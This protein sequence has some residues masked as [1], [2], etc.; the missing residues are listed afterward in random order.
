MKKLLFSLLLAIPLFASAQGLD[1][2]LS[3][4][5][6]NNADVKKL[7]QFLTDQKVYAGDVN[8]NFFS[9]TLKAVKA[10][11]TKQGVVP[12]SGYV[13]TKTR[14]KI[15]VLSVSSA[16]TQASI[17]KTNTDLKT[18]VKLQPE[19]PATTTATSTIPTATSTPAITTPKPPAPPIV[20]NNDQPQVQNP[21]PAPI[22]TWEQR[23]AKGFINAD[24]KGWG[25]LIMT[26]ALGE[27]RYYRKEGNQWVRKNSEAEAGQA[28]VDPQVLEAYRILTDNL[29]RQ[30]EE[31]RRQQQLVSE[32]SRKQSELSHKIYQQQQTQQCQDRYDRAA[33]SSKATAENNYGYYTNIIATTPSDEYFADHGLAYSGYRQQADQKRNEAHAELVRIAAKYDADLQIL[34]GTLQICLNAAAQ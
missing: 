28:Y 26:N 4:G 20:S 25:S 24:Q 1:H 18:P 14:T 22:E 2:D 33:A 21:Q 13:G 34:K 31:N 27:K 30:A 10:F 17:N 19:Q 23:E 7:Q 9:M 3:F 32:E 5:L 11:Q 12:A 15:N 8:G 16:N 29:N 6:R